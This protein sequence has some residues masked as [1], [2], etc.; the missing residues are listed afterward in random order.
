MHVVNFII[1]FNSPLIFF[2]KKINNHKKGKPVTVAE[3]CNA[4]TVF[5]LS[6]AGI[7]GSNPTQGM[8]V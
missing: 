2:L 4:Y 8:N 5:A 6:E 7:M 3:R 1:E